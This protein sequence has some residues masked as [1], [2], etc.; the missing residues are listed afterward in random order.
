MYRYKTRYTC[1]REIQF[2]VENDVVTSVKFI[3][4]CAGNTQGVAK[5]C[6]G[7]SVDEI[8]ALLEG[9]Q[10]RM[11]TSCPDQLAQALKQYKQNKANI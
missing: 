5:L 1:S 9:T 2:E 11:G 7:R 8:I 3:G 10:C 4:G 6:V